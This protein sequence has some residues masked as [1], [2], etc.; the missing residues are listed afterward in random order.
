[1]PAHCRNDTIAVCARASERV[2]FAL[3]FQSPTDFLFSFREVY[4]YAHSASLSLCTTPTIVDIVL[5]CKLDRRIR[6]EWQKVM[7]TQWAS[8]DTNRSDCMQTKHISN[9]RKQQIDC[10]QVNRAS[11]SLSR[12]LSSHNSCEKFNFC[13]SVSISSGERDIQLNGKTISLD[14]LQMEFAGLCCIKNSNGIS[15]PHFMIII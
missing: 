14:F 12:S 5:L 8:N 13:F 1:M 11:Q 2:T 9:F 3:L 7:E 6:R 4:R 10:C 15:I